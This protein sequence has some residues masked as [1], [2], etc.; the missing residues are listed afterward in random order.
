M[1]LFSHTGVLKASAGLCHTA[2]MT[3]PASHDWLI[4][5]TLGDLPR[6][7][8]LAGQMG[9]KRCLAM[10]DGA[11]LNALHRAAKR[12]CDDTID[13]L[14]GLG[15]A[16]DTATRRNL[17]ALDFACQGVHVGAV[18]RLLGAGALPLRP[19]V[20]TAFSR[21]LENR[22]RT[23]AGW[24][25]IEHRMVEVW[26]LLVAAAPVFWNEWL[27]SDFVQHAPPALI[28][29]VLP[30]L[31]REVLFPNVSSGYL[32]DRYSEIWEFGWKRAGRPHA[33]APLEVER[34][35][36]WVAFDDGLPESGSVSFLI[37]DALLKGG[38]MNL[39][40]EFAWRGD[41][42]VIPHARTLLEMGF[43]VNGADSSGDTALMSAIEKNPPLVPLLLEYGATLV[44]GDPECPGKNA[45]AR[46]F[47]CTPSLLPL[48]M[49]A[50]GATEA[51]E[52]LGP[53]DVLGVATDHPHRWT[54]F[55][56]AYPLMASHVPLLCFRDAFSSG[57]ADPDEDIS[58]EDIPEEEA[59]RVRH[60]AILTA[61]V[62]ENLGRHPG[63]SPFEDARAWLG[64]PEAMQILWERSS[65]AWRT[66]LEEALSRPYV[67]VEP[68]R[69]VVYETH[70]RH[71]TPFSCH[72]MDC[73][74]PVMSIHDFIKAPELVPAL[75]RQWPHSPEK[76]S[77]LD[78][79]NAIHGP[80][81]FSG[82]MTL[83]ARHLGTENAPVLESMFGFLKEAGLLATL[84]DGEGGGLLD[85]YLRHCQY[86]S[87]PLHK[88]AFALCLASQPRTLHF[89][90]HA[91]QTALHRAALCQSAEMVCHLAENGFSL[92][93]KDANGQTPMDLLEGDARLAV[94][95]WQEQRTL[96]SLL[97]EAGTDTP[98]RLPVRRGSRRL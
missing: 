32:S 51:L 87:P 43:D 27:L 63:K 8:A 30:T 7:K 89:K 74:L 36:A 84:R 4:A 11:G 81:T 31:P 71:P 12:G 76:V 21:L 26:G 64:H 61:F 25:A 59:G 29:H 69:D 45:I 56:E 92:T 44:G 3:N 2:P 90:N 48:L 9:V 6:L 23:V 80:R 94:L 16:A 83:M 95:A 40:Q 54:R 50:P 22:P 14:L 18:A 86:T 88:D 97:G 5:A 55:L 46:A 53:E 78:W 39:L 33:L 38:D 79:E 77:A 82:L 15:M 91:G 13:W 37:R 98:D 57:Q 62:H 42:S 68:H 58:D 17:T 66:D 49:K 19:N 73:L 65:P 52:A 93:E 20:T 41:K 35:K 34:L 75:F 28:R 47:S 67:E 85:S 96:S 72:I 24:H 10:T 1:F 60:R 70:A